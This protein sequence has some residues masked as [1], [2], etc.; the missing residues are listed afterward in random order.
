[1]SF[2]ST[3]ILSSI[4]IVFPI[5][6]VLLLKTYNKCFYS[7]KSDYLIDCAC[8]IS[9]LLIIK[10]CDN[11]QTY[12]LLLLNIP[13]LLLIINERRFSSYLY[14][15]VL[16]I[17]NVCFGYNIW[18]STIEYVIYLFIFFILDKKYQQYNLYLSVFLFVKGVSLTIENFYILG[19]SSVSVIFKI[20]IDLTIFYLISIVLLQL[21]YLL[22]N[23]IYLNSTL[24]ELEKQKELKN[25]LF[26]IT[27]E[28]KNPLA[29]CK[30][31][32]SMMN[33][34]DI[35][36]VERY[37]K[38][39]DEELDRTLDILNNFSEYNKISVNLNILDLNMLVE[40][41]L[42]L[43]NNLLY[44]K[45]ISLNY[46][47]NYEEIFINGDYERLKQVLINIIKNSIEAI[48]I[49]G[50]I[51]V[52]VIKKKKIVIVKIKDDGIGIKKEDLDKI[53]N[54]FYSSKSKG[55][56]LGVSLSKEIIS[57]HKGL[58]KYNSVYGKYTEVSIHLPLV[59]LDK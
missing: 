59:K 49:N 20:F 44:S 2:F 11:N 15:F 54:L 43:F 14:A 29:V 32:L 40:D 55:T 10:Y 5:I 7:L 58:L 52:D 13:F 26:K 18:L 31:Y 9:L 30:G 57:L 25:A 16:I 3:L 33:Y 34:E 17:F 45:N 23:T 27:H 47:N 8:F 19:N 42:K 50:N 56:G 12:E 53:G 6:S 4:L 48:N 21:I 37:N 51:D 28:V 1:M 36:K 35:K 46:T 24:N 38:I 41:T 22:N 39:I